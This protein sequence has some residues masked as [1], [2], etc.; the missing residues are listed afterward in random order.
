MYPD[1]YVSDLGIARSRGSLLNR[2]TGVKAC[3]AVPKMGDLLD[4]ILESTMVSNAERLLSLVSRK[5]AVPVLDE[6]DK[7]PRSHNEL[8]RSLGIE[9]QQL[10]R[11]LR[12]LVRGGLVH[13]KVNASASPLRVYYSLT[14]LGHT[15]TT[16]IRELR[17]IVGE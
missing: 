10:G 7:G 8:V 9:N 12:E 11:P 1:L 5:W 13:R 15:V 17:V 4:S 16:R 14:V 2:I 6:L 3:L